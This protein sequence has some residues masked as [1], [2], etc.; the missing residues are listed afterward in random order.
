MLVFKMI[1]FFERATEREGER[2]RKKSSSTV[3]HLQV[4]YNVQLGQTQEPWNLFRVS[5]VSGRGPDT[6]TITSCLARH[7]NRSR[8]RS[9]VMGTQISAL[10]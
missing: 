3:V 9:R 6:C 4:G 10:K 8:I 1:Y 2:E 5:H 7:M